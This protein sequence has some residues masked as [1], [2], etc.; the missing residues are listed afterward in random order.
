MHSFKL[1]PILISI[2]MGIAFSSFAQDA[3][4]DDEDYSGLEKILV[5]A[6]KREQNI[7]EVPISISTMSSEMIAQTGVRQLKEVAEYIPNLRI[8]DGTDF[9]SEVTIRGVGANSRNIGFDTRVGVYLDG[10]YLGQSP[11]LNQELLDLERIEVLRGPQGT[12]FGKNT[13]AGAINLISKAPTDTLEGHIGAEFG[14]YSAR[15]YTGSLNLP[16]TDTLWTKLSFN[17]QTRDGYTNNLATGNGNINE[18]DASAYRLQVHYEVTD[19]FNANLALDGMRSD[20][21]SYTGEPVTDTFGRAINTESPRLFEISSTTD[22]VE[23]RDIDGIALTLNWSL[24]NGHDIR[25]ITAFRESDISYSNDSDYSALDLVRIGYQDTYE[26]ASQELQ[27]ISPT[28]NKLQY[29]AGIYLYQ[30]DSDTTRQVFTSPI[31]AGIFGTD[32]NNPVSNTGDV[33]TNS[34]ALFANADYQL[35]PS[36]KLGL[37]LRISQED[38]DVNWITDGTGSGALSHCHR[39]CD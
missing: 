39:Q 30:Q 12:L 8:S 23:D 38:K 19:T 24:N 15:Q 35:S 13:V 3:A 10:V 26:Q 27:L 2:L 18:Q 31:S 25:S 16:V 21:T 17:K 7:N 29:V 37:G 6:Q 28:D 22:P 11:A 9:T 33:K 4:N 5:T 34:Y 1:N 32:P 14:N 20:R 36:L